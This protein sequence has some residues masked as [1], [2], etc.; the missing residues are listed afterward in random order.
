[1]NDLDTAV[2]TRWL[3]RE[4]LDRLLERLA[5]EG[6]L[7]GPVEVDGEV[8][9]RAVDDPARLSR[10]HVN[11]L[12]PPKEYLLPTP[13]RLAAYRVED[14][15][16][17]L[18]D[19]TPQPPRPRVLFGV[20]SCDVAGMA[21]LER[22]FSGAP[23]GADGVPDPAFAARRD[24][25]TVISVV[26]ARTGPTCMCVCCEGGPALARG[27][28]WQLTGLADGWL[29]EIGSA[30]GERL[31]AR[32][33]DVL[34]D[35][36]PGA[37]AAQAAQVHAT[38]EGFHAASRRRVPTMAASRMVSS[39]RVPHGFWAGVGERCFECGGCAFVCPTCSCF[40]V[41]DTVG[42]GEGG[43]DGPVDGIFPNVPGGIT[44]EVRDG[45]YER[46]RL[47]DNCILP[48]FVREAG[49]G[50]P[51]WTCGERCVTRFFH[52]LSWQ[53]HARMGA[54][55][56]TG[57]GRCVLVCLGEEGIDRIATSLTTVLT[58]ASRGDPAVAPARP[59]P[60]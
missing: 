33:A 14:G 37:L 59:V 28:D 24:A 38:V 53:F 7:V 42:V 54:L 57:C 43:F 51:R 20:R 45:R 36:P 19:G 56:C 3:T 27:F 15:R 31:A 1:M 55:G 11:S 8:V 50:Y 35:T 18:E 17:T 47:R 60:G 52:K 6:V 48:G 2:S 32:C 10:D 12:V 13:E 30:R 41:A 40:N 25:T 39:G 21:Y 46:V 44:T 29:V 49:G 58:G 16:A 34:G 5:R 23:F 4:G 9:F 22:F 26:C